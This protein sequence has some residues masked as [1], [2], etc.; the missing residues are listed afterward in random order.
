MWFRLQAVQVHDG[1]GSQLDSESHRRR[2]RIRRPCTNKPLPGGAEILSVAVTAEQQRQRCGIGRL[3]VHAET[4]QVPPRRC[5][6]LRQ[7]LRARAGVHHLPR[8]VP[9]GWIGVCPGA[10]KEWPCVPNR[11]AEVVGPRQ[12]I[13]RGIHECEIVERAFGSREELQQCRQFRVAECGVLELPLHRFRP[14]ISQFHYRA[15]RRRVD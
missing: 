3:C 13:C 8:I 2:C 11:V 5:H 1:A 14:R 9:T 10:G 6:R 4:V 12:Q 15:V 7:V